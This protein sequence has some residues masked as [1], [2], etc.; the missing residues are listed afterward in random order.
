MQ[1]REDYSMIMPLWKTGA[2]PV[3][4]RLFCPDNVILAQFSGS[5]ASYLLPVIEVALLT[6]RI[7]R[8]CGSSDLASDV[9]GFITVHP[10]QIV[11]RY[12]KDAG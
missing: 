7:F 9:C 10:G 6:P 11:E 4:H 5:F 8:L 3:I 1:R 12:P 2:E